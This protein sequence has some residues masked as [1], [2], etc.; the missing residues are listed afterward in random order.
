HKVG[1]DRATVANL[2]RLLGLDPAVRQMVSKNEL[3]LGQAKVLLSITDGKL[4]HSMAEKARS[5]SLSVRALEKL[6][7]KPKPEIAVAASEDD[8]LRAMLAKDLGEEIQKLIGTK[9]VLDY[10]KGK[11]KI[12]IHFYS[13]SEL[14]QVADR[15]RSSWQR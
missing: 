14:N 10:D 3:S 6:V 4:Q 2:L 5:E 1:K 15:L 9:V 12:A 7:A 13:D 11:G 8:Q